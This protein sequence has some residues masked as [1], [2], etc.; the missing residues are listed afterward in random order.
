MI[1]P[2][3]IKEQQRQTCVNHSKSNPQVKRRKHFIQRQDHHKNEKINR[4][5]Q[6]TRLRMRQPHIVNHHVMN[7]I[8]IRLKRSAIAYQS[9]GKNPRSIKKRNKK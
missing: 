4:R 2:V 8:S 1:V 3:H 9:I 7:V 5:Q 6:Q